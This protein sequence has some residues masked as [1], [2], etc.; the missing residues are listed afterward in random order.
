MVTVNSTN[1]AA[2]G[3]S[4][5][6]F[7]VP[8]R[9]SA[10]GRFVAFTSTR[11]D[12]VQGR[13]MDGV[14]DVYLRDIQAG[15]TSIVSVAPDGMA[16]GGFAPQMT[17]DGRYVLF[18]SQSTKLVTPDANGTGWDVFRRD[19]QTNTTLTSASTK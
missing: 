15:R 8:V 9:I 1:T 14:A 10:D 3:N 12:F 13:D 19:L 6:L 17:R 4:S 11:F 7:L 2:A 16:A 5:D 18:N